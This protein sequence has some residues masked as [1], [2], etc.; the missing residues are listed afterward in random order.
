M[1]IDIELYET[2]HGTCP[3]EDWFE[4]LREERTQVKIAT[5]LDRFKMGNFGNCKPLGDGVAEL[6][7]DYGP[8]FRVYYSK[9]RNSIILLLCGG[10]KGSQDKDIEKAKEYL[11]EYRSRGK[12]YGKK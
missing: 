5:R 9:G 12:A 4:S 6:R 2:A 11:R 8:G 3:Y 7:I 10:D 1:G